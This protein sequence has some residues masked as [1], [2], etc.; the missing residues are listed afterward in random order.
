MWNAEGP[1]SLN[2]L[3]LDSD[4][5]STSVWI[6]KETRSVMQSDSKQASKRAFCI[7]AQDV[8]DRQLYQAN[9]T[10]NQN[11]HAEVEDN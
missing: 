3:A 9:G 11:W 6:Q 7:V 8:H 1:T 10:Q 5:V 2:S 4:N